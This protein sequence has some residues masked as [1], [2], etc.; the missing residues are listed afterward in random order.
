MYRTPV[1]RIYLTNPEASR[2]DELAGTLPDSHM[3]LR[4]EGM[5]LAAKGLTT[6][7]EVERVLG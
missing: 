5:K 7:S 3:T 1:D 2:M 6:P 4:D